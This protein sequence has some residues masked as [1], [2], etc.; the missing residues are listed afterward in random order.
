MTP[1]GKEFVAHMQM[2]TQVA[3]SGKP[4][5]VALAVALDDD[6]WTLVYVAA[7]K[8]ARDIEDQTSQ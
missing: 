8:M 2:A 7:L 4:P 5:F 1:R 3:Q 6:D